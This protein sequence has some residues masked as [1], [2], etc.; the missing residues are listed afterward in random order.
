LFPAL[1]SRE[2]KSTQSLLYGEPMKNQR[3]TA[4]AALLGAL[5]LAGCSGGSGSTD[6]STQGASSQ[7][8]STQGTTAGAAAQGSSMQGSS[9]QGAAPGQGSPASRGRF[10]KILLSLG[11]SD[12]QKTQVRAII[13]AARAQA[14]T[15]DPETRRATMRAAY[16]KIE[17]TVLTPAQRATFETKMAALRA[18]RA[19]QAPQAQTQ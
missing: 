1:D 3:I 11:L 9:M 13:A 5:V 4:A 7:T 18:Q 15:Q 10:G 16:T 8:A 12:E 14:K 2:R 17:T 19:A 6:A